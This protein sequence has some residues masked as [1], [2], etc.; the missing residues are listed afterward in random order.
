[1][2]TYPSHMSDRAGVRSGRLQ[3]GAHADADALSCVGVAP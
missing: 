2:Y 3:S 1:M